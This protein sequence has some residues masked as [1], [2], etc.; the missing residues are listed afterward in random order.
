VCVYGREIRG[1]YI[2][3]ASEREGI[4][5]DQWKEGSHCQVR[6]LVS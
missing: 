4:T 3:Y 2:I 5:R 1:M 6:I